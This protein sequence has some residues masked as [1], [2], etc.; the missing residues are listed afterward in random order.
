MKTFG[1]LRWVWSNTCSSGFNAACYITTICIPSLKSSLWMKQLCYFMEA[2]L[3]IFYFW[4]SHVLWNTSG[5]D[6]GSFQFALPLLKWFFLLALVKH[7]EFCIWN[8]CE[9][10]V[11]QD[12]EFG[13]PIKAAKCEGVHVKFE[14]WQWGITWGILRADLFVHCKFR[15]S[16][17]YHMWVLP[18]SWWRFIIGLNTWAS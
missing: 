1:C 15:L 4:N 9:R 5:N 3:F 18:C 14:I 2:E 17:V 7:L 13:R 8:S 16:L 10:S 6:L 11:L 12:Q